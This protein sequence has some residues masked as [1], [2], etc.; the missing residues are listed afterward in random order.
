LRKTTETA[1]Y[2]IIWQI[3]Q[4]ELD[5]KKLRLL[6]RQPKSPNIEVFSGGRRLMLRLLHLV[7]FKLDLLLGFSIVCGV[8]QKLLI[9]FQPA[10][11]LIQE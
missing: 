5:E 11:L 10:L 9:L 2:A 7:V 4:A 6:L 8:F 3:C 1:K